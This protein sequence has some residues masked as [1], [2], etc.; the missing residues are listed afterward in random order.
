M[1]ADPM[2]KAERT[3]EPRL[4][5]LSPLRL[6]AR[7]VSARLSPGTL[8]VRTGQG[9]DRAASAAE[10]LAR[11][12]HPPAVAVAGVAGALVAGL[13]PG[14]VVVADRIVDQ[15][16]APVAHLE[17]AGLIASALRRRGL[18]TVV[19]TIATSDRIVRG[20]AR[21]ALAANGALAVDMES[22]AL[23]G[24]PWAA[25]TAVVRTVADTPEHELWSPAVV[26]SGARALSALRAAAPAL[27]EWAEAVQRRR[28][29]LAGP[30]SF[31]AGVERAIQTVERAI[32]K[33]GPPVYVRR[34]IV[35]NRHV[36]EDLERRGAV[37][38]HELDDVPDGAT[39]VFSAHGVSP[40]VRDEAGGKGLRV[41]DATCPL[42]AKVHREVRRFSE[43]GYQV[44]LIGHAGHDETEGTLGE[45]DGITLIE[46]K[47][48][49][50][51]LDV[52]D[53]A[54]I[55]YIT[56]TTLS[57]DDVTDMV[58]ALS[59]RFPSV[60]GPSAADICYA[61]Q[62][63]QDAVRAIAADCDLVLVIGSPNSSN[64]ARLVEVAN[65]AG[66]R[67]VMIDDETEIDLRWLP[68]V[69][70]VG[71]TAGASAPPALVERV[72]SSLQGLAGPHELEI[73]ERSV[74]TENVNFPLP[75]EVR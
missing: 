58:G 21:S 51:E 36:V 9:P 71:V 23:L 6:E 34:Q 14:T 54:K 68:G 7:A 42:V 52:R 63:R 53:P 38:V 8:V 33:Y 62:N 18:R 30:R 56:Q 70:T 31:C 37:F 41:V 66:A 57:P 49:I 1:S 13:A 72:V 20:P 60:V 64:T 16:G 47:S 35:H 50:D 5:V 15:K 40:D 65:R 26:S 43:R 19:G 55:A 29:I 22:A 67:A 11:A 39:V 59:E 28:V 2:P 10:A 27:E 48:D 73:E 17:S 4:L 75:L 44:V 74:R 24:R 25:A 12:P 61:T 46:E 45:A 3:A 69:S 32:D